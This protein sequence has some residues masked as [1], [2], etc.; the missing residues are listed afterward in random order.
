MS[1]VGS[2]PTTEALFSEL[3]EEAKLVNDLFIC[4]SR[5]SLF[6]HLKKGLEW[7]RQFVKTQ[8]EA[9]WTRVR[10]STAPLGG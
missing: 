4:M 10:I 7:F 9:D 2:N 8:V 3:Q 5:I 1:W 6:I